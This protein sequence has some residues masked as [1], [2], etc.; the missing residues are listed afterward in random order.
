MT[1]SNITFQSPQPKIEIYNPD[2]SY[3]KFSFVPSKENDNLIQSV[4]L[5]SY[6]FSLS[7]NDI[8]GSFS[9]TLFPD[10]VL[11]YQRV[12]IFDRIEIRDVVMIYE[13][14][15]EN[16]KKATPVFTGVVTRKKYVVQAGDSGSS[17]RLSIS[18]TAITALA[19]QFR[20]ELDTR[21]I[22]LR[23]GQAINDTE[24][25]IQQAHKQQGTI[26]AAINNLHFSP[27]AKAKDIIQE[28][29]KSYTNVSSQFSTT[30]IS[31]EIHNFLTDDFIECDDT[32][33]IKYPMSGAMLINSNAAQSFDNFL[34]T[35]FP[36]PLYEKTAYTTDNGKMKIRIRQVP[37]DNADWEKLNCYNIYPK[38]TKSI[39][40]EQSDKEVYTSF[41][42]YLNGS[43]TSQDF[44]YIKAAVQDKGS[45]LPAFCA[46]KFAIYGFRPLNCTFYGYE[47][48]DSNTGET[49]NDKETDK[50]EELAKEVQKEK[51]QTETDTATLRSINEK[52]AEWY[53][54]L[55]T[56]LQ[57]SLSL[58][59]AY[60]DYSR[61]MPGDK[62][63]LSGCEFY[64]EG[65]AHSWNY[66][67]GGDIN[68]SLSRGGFYDE[69]GKYDYLSTN[70]TS[71]I[72]MFTEN[73]ENAENGPLVN[74]PSKTLETKTSVMP[75]VLRR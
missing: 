16:N 63:Y 27:G 50:A 62:V 73:I 56:M 43:P 59:M 64:V 54:S 5:Q 9:L 1:A 51:D 14:S 3:C 23:L 61:I 67:S 58:A 36:A 11:R 26:I 31:Q 25:I 46:D 75:L 8:Q 40:L 55:D 66:G 32:L 12:S 38:Y 6:Q 34:N 68:I 2:R 72:K 49:G 15:A 52:L 29:W 19:A 57:G 21:A 20:L 71:A 48:A 70:V 24:S 41:F 53:G 44:N 47:T 37:F 28:I 69:N 13:D 39:E 33:T 22:V 7:N 17:R 42:S 60:N 30:A 10:I 18:G 35:L 65:I 4:G 74:K 45:D